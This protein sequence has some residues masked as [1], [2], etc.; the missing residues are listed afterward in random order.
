MKFYNSEQM[1]ILD[2]LRGVGAVVIACFF[3]YCHFT[4]RNAALHPLV[5]FFPCFSKYGWLAVELFCLISGMTFMTFY[6]RKIADRKVSGK[7]FFL[8]RFSRL[9]PIYFVFLIVILFL[10]LLRKH[11][12]LPDF[13]V[14]NH[15]GYSFLCNL[16]LAQCWGIGGESSFN[17]VTWTLSV[18]V[19]CYIVFWIISRYSTHPLPCFFAV[20]ALLNMNFWGVWN[21]PALIVRGG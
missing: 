21:P 12:G 17:W 15:N 16:F 14:T 1:K 2:V 18:E 3:H 13:I 11:V 4:Q 6:N 8:A 20:I 5:N 9:Y 19:L 10:I 7:N